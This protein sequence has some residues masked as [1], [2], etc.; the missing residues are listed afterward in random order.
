MNVSERHGDW[1]WGNVQSAGGICLIVRDKLYF[2]VSGRA[3]VPG[4][5][6]SGICTTGLATLRRDGFASMDADNTEGMLTTRPLS[7]IGKHLFVN[8]DAEQGDLRV[9][10]LDETGRVIAPFSRDNC[11]PIR[12][13]KTL[14]AIRWKVVSDM[15]VV[16]GKPVRFRFYLT[17]GRLYAFWVSPAQSG[18]SYGYVA[19]GGPGLTSSA[20]TV[21]SAA[22][23]Q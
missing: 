7:F 19:A 17:S 6:S 12:V 15:S 1:N 8:V 20:D 21:G 2:Y 10:I 9:E 3:G 5:D 14:Q 16:V 23:Q 13:N 22:Y 11:V 18:A 4:S